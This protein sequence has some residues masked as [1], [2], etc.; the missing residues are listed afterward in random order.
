M[1]EARRL[2][3]RRSPGQRPSSKL[4]RQTP[5]AGFRGRRTGFV[6]VLVARR[7]DRLPTA[8]TAT[9][10]AAPR[11]EQDAGEDEQPERDACRQADVVDDIDDC[12]SGEVRAQP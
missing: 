12:R 1:S 11:L 3:S 5:A 4:S 8:T 2:P 7:R 10:T 6:S 9:A